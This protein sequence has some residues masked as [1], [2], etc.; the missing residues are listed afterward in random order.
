MLRAIWEYRAFVANLVRREFEIRSARAVWGNV[1]LVL[2]PATQILIYTLIF[3]HVLGARLAGDTNNMAYGIYICAGII[4]WNFFHELVAKS[5]TIFLDHAPLLKTVSFPR[6]ALPIALVST[7]CINLSIVATIFLAV[8]VLTGNSPGLVLFAAI[9]L[10]AVQGAIGIGFGILTGTLNV[11]Y[12]DIGRIVGVLMQFW[13]WLTPVVYPQSI[14]PDAI[15]PYYAWN[16]MVPIV[17][18][19]HKIVLEH[20]IPAWDTIISPFVVAML[21]VGL[22]WFVF[23]QLSRDLVDEL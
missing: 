18:G 10:L 17:D 16:P 3:G 15:A 11:F 12:R 8:L 6:F 23:R 5:Q 7:A 22:G 21:S 19:Y 13:F 9:P 14:I 4:T 1:W 2:E 20:E